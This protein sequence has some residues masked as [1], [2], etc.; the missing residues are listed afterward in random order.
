MD[1]ISCVTGTQFI[2]LHVTYLIF[3]RLNLEF[4]S[5]IINYDNLPDQNVSSVRSSKLQFEV[6]T[7]PFFF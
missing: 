2:A 5:D 7:E 1:D 4:V 6:Q 3:L